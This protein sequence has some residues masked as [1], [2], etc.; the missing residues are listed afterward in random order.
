MQLC[1]VNESRPNIAL[2]KIGQELDKA[3]TKCF[4][5]QSELNYVMDVCRKA[6]TETRESKEAPDISSIT[7]SFKNPGSKSPNETNCCN[8]EITSADRIANFNI[9]QSIHDVEFKA[10]ENFDTSNLSPKS[11]RFLPGKSINDDDIIESLEGRQK[12]SLLNVTITRTQLDKKLRSITMPAQDEVTEVDAVREYE[13][14]YFPSSMSLEGLTSRADKDYLR[15]TSCSATRGA[16]D[17]GGIEDP[18]LNLDAPNVVKARRAVKR[19]R[20]RTGRS[21]M[22]SVCRADNAVSKMRKR[23]AK[24]RSSVSKSTV[25]TKDTGFIGRK[26]VKRRRHKGVAHQ[27]S[28]PPKHVKKFNDVVEIFHNTKLK[29]NNSVVPSKRFKAN[30]AKYE[31][32]THLPATKENSRK[33]QE[34]LALTPRD[35]CPEHIDRECQSRNKK[36]EEDHCL[37]ILNYQSNSRTKLEVA[38]EQ[39]KSEEHSN[40]LVPSRENETRQRAFNRYDDPL[41][42][43]NYEMP[44]LASKLKRSGRSYFS[45]F[46][47]RNIPFVVGTSV[48]PSYN[49][50]LN[51]QQVLSVMKTRQPI[52]SDVTPLLL[53]KVSR[54]MR[55]VSVL[56][57]QINYEGSISHVS[58]QMTGTSFSGGENLGRVKRLPFFNLQHVG[59]TQSGCMP[60]VSTEAG[61]ISEK[62]DNAFKQLRPVN[63]SCD[64]KTKL[65]SSFAVSKSNTPASPKNQEKISRILKGNIGD[66][67]RMLDSHNSKEIRDVLINLHDQFEEMNTKY[68]RLQSE[69]SKSN[70]KSMKKELFALNKELNAKE[71]EI[72]TVIGLY[73]EVMTLK[74]QMKMLHERNSLVCI[75]TE[76]AKGT[77]G[78]DPFSMPVVLGKSHSTNATQILGRRK[79]YNATRE[80]PASL[81][82]AALLRQIQTFHKQLQRV[83]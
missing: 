7:S 27:P 29:N 51:I 42:T 80:P 65:Q 55:P 76:S 59:K 39:N 57:D 78:R 24:I 48:T 5:L 32:K 70:D 61:I 82:L 11:G 28:N 69:V 36:N 6:Q 52:A 26:E 22:N 62:E 73:K 33:I 18:G 43:P 3:E 53:R 72:N 15:A 14:Y 64:H 40:D 74:Q 46:N 49:L 35:R 60:K 37:Q 30:E 54:G 25:T 83:S 4:T 8:S 71:E 58:S 79:I 75:T 38:Q 67:I 56:L 63:D 16:E 1:K 10:E 68:E 19:D 21:D 77:G 17:V 20:S 23:K 12:G 2:K 41:F 44:T 81:Q 13:S 45:R 34:T 9:P 66:K 50:G 31:R 47:F